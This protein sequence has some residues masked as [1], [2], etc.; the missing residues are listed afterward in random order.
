MKD[1]IAL[2]IARF[3]LRQEWFF[4]AA[5]EALYMG[6]MHISRNPVRRKPAVVDLPKEGEDGQ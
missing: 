6:G 5:N 4:V 2:W 1:K 3:L